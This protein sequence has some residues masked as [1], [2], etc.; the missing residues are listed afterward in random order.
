MSGPSRAPRRLPREVLADGLRVLSQRD[1]DLAGVLGAYGPPPMWARPPGFSTLVHIILEQ[2][3]SLA[4]ARAAFERL[5]AVVAPITP[6]RFL[7]LDDAT[8][9][10]IGFSRQKAAY[11]RHLAQAI[12]DHRFALGTLAHMDD[13]VARA[14]LTQLDG[15]GGWTADIYL[16]MALRRGDVWPHG[17][18]ALAVAAH[19]VKHLPA[20]PTD[21]ELSDL[22]E[23]WR[24]W[25]SVAARVLWHFYL[26]QRQR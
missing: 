13:A 3:V 7:G 2:Q 16:M 9:R 23:A 20:R 26:C 5:R 15:V 19:Q 25:R 4:S 18:L 21:H 24:P 22:S 10:A 14:A 1:Q 8:L 11:A 17:D 12:A 6:R